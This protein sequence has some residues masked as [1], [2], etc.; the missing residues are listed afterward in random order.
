V[1]QRVAFLIL[2]S[3]LLAGCAGSPAYPPPLQRPSFDAVPE[4]VVRFVNMD[5]F[6]AAEYIV[7]DI[8]D[9]VEGGGWRWTH[10]S[11][12]LRFRLDRTERLKLIMDFAFPETNFKDTGP[13]TVSFFVNNKLLDR[14]RYE[15]FGA[16]HFEK[17]VP[18]P[19]LHTG[20]DTLVRADVDPP[21]IAPSDNA[22]LGFVLYRAGFIQ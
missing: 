21:W 7:K 6:N 20:Q 22:K 15:T 12:E 4:P 2:S 10:Q 8:Q 11:P 19:W 1:E 16:K 18:D 9:T 13:V 3:L 17:A 14:V 5:D